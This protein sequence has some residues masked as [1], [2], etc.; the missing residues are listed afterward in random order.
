M[1]LSRDRPVQVFFGRRKLQPSLPWMYAF[2]GSVA[3]TLMLPTLVWV[4][5]A[6]KLNYDIVQ[7]N[8]P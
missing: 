6:A 5:I 7:L 3:A 8:R 2:W 4:T 1:A